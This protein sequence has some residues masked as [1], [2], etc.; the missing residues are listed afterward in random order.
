MSI[1]FARSRKASEGAEAYYAYAAQVT[2]RFDA[3]IAEKGQLWMETN[4][5]DIYIYLFIIDLLYGAEEVNKSVKSFG[6]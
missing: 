4:W 3:D 2:P 6:L 5:L 1:F